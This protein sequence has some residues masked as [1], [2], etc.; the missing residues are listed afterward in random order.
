MSEQSSA[1][2]DPILESIALPH[3]LRDYQKRAVAFL[4]SRK[5]ALLADDMGLGKTVECIV[6]LR[7]LHGQVKWKRCLVVVPTS[8]RRNW[9]REIETWAPEMR[10]RLVDGDQKEREAQY[11]LPFPLLIA[12]YAQIRID[13][14]L[15]RQRDSFDVV[16]LDEAQRIKNRGSQTSLACTTIPRE[17][18]W[19]LTGTPLENSPEDLIAIFSFVKRGVLES[20]MPVS[21]L[22]RR[23]SPYTLRRTVDEVL[24]ELPERIEQTLEHDLTN[25]QRKAYNSIWENREE[26]YRESGSLLALI[27][28]LKQICNYEPQSGASS[29]LE[30]LSLVLENTADENK[31]I[32]VFSQYVETLQ[33]IQHQLDQGIVY[34][35]EL[36]EE[37]RDRAL[38]AF[39]DREGPRLL[40]M[41][42]TAGS[43]GLNIQEADTVVLFD[44]WWNPAVEEQAIRRA[45]RLGRKRPLHILKFVVRD[46]VEERIVSIL[47][48]KSSLFDEV[49]EGMGVDE[50]QVSDS[51][52]E[53]IL[54][55]GDGPGDANS[56]E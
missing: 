9:K 19:A 14:H 50:F 38:S 51:E 55:L 43:V 13:R 54:E 36:D 5:S 28:D 46:T 56:S 11:L 42:L 16:V 37:Q 32:L 30:T 47:E 24:P 49:V 45:Y 12:S 39:Q 27:T 29:K 17:R 35:G 33:W 7:V 40:L 20:G 10:P 18:S 25:E 26:L 2:L 6:A 8:L 15:F 4:T 22:R 44:R 3:E 48:R 21:M 23:A 41:S 52:L 53:W 34:H 1:D 31:K